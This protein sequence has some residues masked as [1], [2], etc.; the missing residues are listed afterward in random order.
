MPW[1]SIAALA[2]L[3][4]FYLRLSG[5]H[6]LPPVEAALYGIAILGAAFLLTWA[7]EV[8]QLDIS[9][10]FALAILALIA[11]LPEYA[12]DLYFAWTAASKPE[13]AAFAAANMTGA[14][15]LLVGVGWSFIV[16]LGW[17]KTHRGAI[18][19]EPAHRVELAFL[20]VATLY[21]FILPFKG[22]LSLLDAV[23]LVGLFAWYAW[24]VAQMHTVEPELV[25]PAALISRLPT[26]TRRVVTIGLFLFAAAAIFASAEPFAESLVR[27]GTAFGI[28]EFLLVQWLAPLASETPEFIVAALFTWRG[29]ATAGFGA[30][31][32]SKINQWTLLIGTIPVVY[33]IA[34]GEPRA[35]ALD[36]R[37]AEEI[38]LTA[39]QS[40]FALAVMVNLIISWRGAVMLLLLFAIQFFI[41]GT[42]L[43]VSVVYLVLAVALLARDRKFILPLVGKGLFSRKILKPM[44]E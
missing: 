19:L 26:T 8:A 35:M 1:I 21:A 6:A 23:V 12:V 3:P 20:T 31:I 24:R 43:I 36:A 25:G 41:P 15:R 34:S 5:V 29:L 30:L 42:H 2:A 4:A 22:S 32:S 28:D 37:Q 39:S 10:A 13:Y 38:F 33:S 7:A 16:F 17:Y 44:E 18:T 40:L 9:Q 11:V 27:T 14:N